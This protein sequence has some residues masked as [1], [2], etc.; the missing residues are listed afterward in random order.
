[1]KKRLL[2]AFLMICMLLTMT[3][4]VAFAADGGDSSTGTRVAGNVQLDK[5][6][7]D[8]END[9]TDVTLTIG[10]T[11]TTTAA[12]VVFVLDKSTSTNVKDE[13]LAMLD[14]LK[15]YT[16]DNN[17]QVNVGVVTFNKVANNKEFNLD[18]TELNAES[19]DKIE[20]IFNKPLSDGTNIEAGIRAGMAMLEQDTDVL[21][22]NKHLVLVTDGVTYLWGT[23]DTPKTM[24]VQF[25]GA[26]NATQIWS[27]NSTAASVVD[28]NFFKITQLD[29]VKSFENPAQWMRDNAALETVINTYQTNQDT[30]PAKYV[31]IEN[32][33]GYISNDAAIYM[34]GKAWQ[35]AADAGYRLYAFASDKYAKGTDANL[36]EEGYYPWASAFIGNLDT[37]GGFSSIF[38]EDDE[39]DYSG[40]FDG[41]KNTVLYEIM[42]GTINDVIGD[43]FDLT[44]AD[45]IAADTFK[46]T[47][48]GEEQAAS[49]DSA[50]SNVVKFGSPDGSG[51]YPYV[52]TYYSNGK[53]ADSREQ[54]DLAINVPVESTKPLKLTYNLTLKNKETTSGTYS[55]PTNEEATLTYTPTIGNETTEEFPVPKVSYTVN[56]V[57]V[58]PPSWDISKSK[59]ATNLDA[60]YESDVTL[61]LPAADYERTMDV[62]FVID[63]SHA[64]SEIFEESVGN[65]LDELAAKDTMDIKV[66]VVAFDAVSRDWLSATSGGKYSGLVS[67]KNDDALAALKTAVSTQL[68]YS[69][70]GYTMKVGGTNTEWPVDMAQDMLAAGSGEE[71]YLI[72]FSDLYGY[73]YRG[74]LTIGDTTYSNVPVSK[75]ID[76]WDQGSMSMGTQYTT[77]AEAYA[78]RTVSDTTPDGFFRDSS[79]DSY[80]S[81]YGNASPAN[82][83]KTAYQVGSHTFSGFEKSLC[84]TYDNLVEAAKTAHVIVVNNSFPIGED[85]PYAQSMVQEM[86]DKLEEAGAVKSYRY[87]TNKAEEA[88][89]GGAAAGVFDG[90]REDLVQLVDAGSQVVDVIGNGQDENGVAYNFDF[91][92]DIANLKLTVNG[93]ALNVESIT[94]QDGA[95]ASYGF[96]KTEVDNYQFVLNYYQNGTATQSGEHFVWKINVPVTKDAPVQLTYTVKLTNPQTDAGS[97]GRYDA[98]GSEGY[99]GLCTNNSATLYPV[100]SNGKQGLPE[101]FAKP[102]VSYTAGGITITP[103][104]ITIYTGG[105]GYDSVVN[106]SG[107]EIGSTTNGLPTPGFYIT[108]PASL[109]QQ[110]LKQ[111]NS[112]DITV[113]D[114]G[115]KVI[116]LSKYLSFTYD[117]GQGNTRLWKLERY[118]K[119]D[120]HASMAYNKYIYRILPAEVND[121]IIPIRLQFTDGDTFMTSDDFTVNLNDLYHEYEMTIYG[122]ALQQHLVKAVITIDKNDSVY[123]AAV[124]PG[125]LTVRG[126]T[127]DHT[128]TTEVVTTTPETEVSNVT[129]QVNDGTHF[130]I[131]GSELEVEEGNQ[132]KLLVDSLVP[133]SE[134]TL[135]NSAVEEFNSITDNY[136]YETRYLDLVDTTN[137]NVYVTASDTVAIYWPYPEGTD[138][139]TKFQIVHY[140]GLDR[141]DNTDL[142]EGDYTMVLYSEENGNLENTDQGIKISVDSF[143]PFALFWEKESSGGSSSRPTPD[144]LNTEDHFAYIIGYP[145]DYQTGE[146]T[147][148]ES[149]WPIEP[150]GDIT[151]AEVA[152]IFFRMLTDEARSTNWS[153]TNNFTDVAS[154]DWY[155]NAISTLANMGILSGDPDGSFRPNDSITRAEFTKIAV[156]FFDEAGNYVDGTYADVPANAWYADFIDAAVDLGLIEGY[157]DGT[158]HPEASITRAEACTIVNRTL[159]RVPDKDHLLPTSKMRVWPDNRDT[160][161]WYYAQMQEATNSHDYEWTGAENNQIENW[162]EKLEDRDWAALEKEWSDANSAPGGEVMD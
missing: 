79:W 55:V 101:N 151:R 77:F 105:D 67:L 130:F 96:G 84:L 33:T 124:T 70:T 32:N 41:V 7:T 6:A 28:K 133:G 136:D 46:L 39:N 49:V 142:G 78:N 51:T 83:I 144:D 107:N 22:E 141:N 36:N 57:P 104:D 131:N 129:A 143:S 140:E 114:N 53:D 52:L 87:R 93:T 43:D 31:S 13:A 11:Q 62:V 108:L 106:G 35:D 113:N 112:A 64:G 98:D 72:M 68:S 42:S 27:S 4:T 111:V 85:A 94:P 23:E 17:L 110:L 34:A 69:G 156:S 95:T 137:G 154:T 44:N 15:N 50:N 19:R 40:M 56:D 59:T 90:I 92:N 120:G 123:D 157:P 102:T 30:T 116:D 75:R 160:G 147:D 148:D 125:K 38:D 128:A 135:V 26:D 58:T 89:T 8:L 45:S 2:S 162:T 21:P 119:H 158:I 103:A 71:K 149:R 61:A 63:D 91:V 145:K 100:D 127:D 152:T 97:Y 115:D 117:D 138:K 16:T 150:Q 132:V 146:P 155:N 74:D 5:T 14:E 80:W 29:Y 12:D 86:L 118:D 65:L 88:L 47:V 54:F 159:G 25:K 24:Y 20:E 10:A 122:G 73:I 139:N 99:T 37:I 9:Q 60:N 134:N 161:A 1:M 82:T 153:Q 18:L 109:N 3:P 81:I 76:T 66:G 48:G 126:I 121:Q